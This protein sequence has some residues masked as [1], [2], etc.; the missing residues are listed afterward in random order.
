L[1]GPFEE[2]VVPI[3]FLREQGLQIEVASGAEAALRAANDIKPTESAKST[4]PAKST[5]LTKEGAK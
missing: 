3:G 2:N 5:E 1:P 4:E